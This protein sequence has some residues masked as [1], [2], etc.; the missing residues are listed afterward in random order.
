MF[1]DDDTRW[2]R[3]SRWVGTSEVD[4]SGRFDVLG[5]PAGDRY[6]AVA[7]DGAARAVLVQPEML[8]ALR[9]FATPL[10]IDERGVHELALAAVARPR[11]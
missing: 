11:P 6:L 4:Q 10:R 5:L 9:P 8:Q 2:I 1:T 7:V 3:G